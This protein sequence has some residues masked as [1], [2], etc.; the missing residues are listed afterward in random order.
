MT[1]VIEKAA[2]IQQLGELLGHK[3]LFCLTPVTIE[4]I[5]QHYFELTTRIY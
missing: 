2:P 5:V 1:Q 3:S 4:A